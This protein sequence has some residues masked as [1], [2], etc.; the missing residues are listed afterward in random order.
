MNLNKIEHFSKVSFSYDIAI[1]DLYS[2]KKSVTSLG[3]V[4]DFN[5]NLYDYTIISPFLHSREVSRLLG[6]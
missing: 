2:K 4:T 6:Q 5:L 1:I 3:L